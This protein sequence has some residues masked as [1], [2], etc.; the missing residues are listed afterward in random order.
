MT[1]AFGHAKLPGH[2][3]LASSH[4]SLP[5]LWAAS[6]LLGVPL[7]RTKLLYCNRAQ[8]DDDAFAPYDLVLVHED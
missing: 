4:L 8:Q 7:P 1:V 3:C 6:L 2:D 5:M